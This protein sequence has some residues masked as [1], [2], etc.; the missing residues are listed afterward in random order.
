MKKLI[1]TFLILLMIIPCSVEA[2]SGCCS[3]H[4]GVAGCNSSGRQICNDGTLSP[5]CTCTPVVQYVYGCTD[6]NAKNYNSQ[7][8]KNDGNCTYY[9]YGCTDPEAKNYNPSA[10]KNDNNCT[11]YIK[12]CT[13]QNA[14]NYNS[15]AEKDDG[16][17]VQKV[18]GCTDKTATNYNET[19]NV[20]DQSCKYKETKSVSN[21]IRDSEKDNANVQNQNPSDVGAGILGIGTL[22]T[23]GYFLIKKFKK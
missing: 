19:A 4:G 10:D 14:K 20:D 18:L 11:Y 12:G 9:I 16:S 8:T 15:N 7:A 2:K 21:E 1:L 13:D 22:G 23:A 5:T 3:Y 17:C 6:Q